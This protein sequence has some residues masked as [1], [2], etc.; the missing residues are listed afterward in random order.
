MAWLIPADLAGIACRLMRHNYFTKQF[1]YLHG[2]Q[3]EAQGRANSI[4]M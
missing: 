4:V 2:A 3:L 1:G